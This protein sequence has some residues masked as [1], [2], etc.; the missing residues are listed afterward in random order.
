MVPSDFDLT[1]FGHRLRARAAKID[2]RCRVR[3]DEGSKAGEGS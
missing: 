1:P 2:G 3:E